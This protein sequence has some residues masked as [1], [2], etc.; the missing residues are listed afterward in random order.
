MQVIITEKDK[1]YSIQMWID[2]L[3]SWLVFD[4]FKSKKQAQK[5]LADKKEMAEV[6]GYIKRT[7]KG[8]KE[9]KKKNAR[10]KSKTVK[11]KQSVRRKKI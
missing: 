9:L 4:N 1:K 3:K 5:F 11:H 8:E 10:N 2:E 7:I 6:K